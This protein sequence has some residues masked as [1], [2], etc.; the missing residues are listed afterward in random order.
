MFTFSHERKRGLVCV[1]VRVSKQARE[2][3]GGGELT[4]RKML[5]LSLIDPASQD[6]LIEQKISNWPGVHHKKRYRSGQSGL[7]LVFFLTDPGFYTMVS[8]YLI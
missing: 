7:S 6:Q 4:T 5:F 1:R 8:Q 3:G 2:R